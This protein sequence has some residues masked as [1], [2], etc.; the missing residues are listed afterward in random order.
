M[1]NMTAAIAA[2]MAMTAG[3]GSAQSAQSAPPQQAPTDDAAPTQEAH[4]QDAPE[5]AAQEADAPPACVPECRSGYLCHEGRCVSACNPPCGPGERCADGECLPP[6][7]PP[8][9]TYAGAGGGFQ[10]SSEPPPVAEPEPIADDSVHRHDGFMLR[11]TLGVGYGNLGQ[12]VAVS[13]PAG[14]STSE[15]DGGGVAGSF[16]IDLGGAVTD[17][18]TIH[19]RLSDLVIVDP[20]VT[21][22]GRDAGTAEDLSMAAYLIAPAITFYAMPAN[23][24]GTLAIGASW[25]SFDVDGDEADSSEV[26]LGLNLDVGKEW[27]V[28]DQWG[29]GIAGRF[30]LTATTET[31][32]ATLPPTGGTTPESI[33]V[34]NDLS[35]VGAAV[36]FSATLQ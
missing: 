19:A 16:S 22:D 7:P 4:T 12:D 11:L 8:P 14:N 33:E 31:D 34:E 15:W 1:K 6:H 20:D 21:I 13:S 26:G 36:L 10:G 27:W 25:V 18:I 5:A 9:P 28:G 30:W 32:T 23:V 35:V 3:T 2:A 17:S 24:Y 29:L